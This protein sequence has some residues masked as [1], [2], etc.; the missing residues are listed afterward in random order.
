MNLPTLIVLGILIFIV[1][2]A[3][4]SIVLKRKNGGGC[5]CGCAGCTG[6]CPS[7]EKLKK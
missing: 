2:L 5:G 6:K 4:R 1:A 7:S 3:I